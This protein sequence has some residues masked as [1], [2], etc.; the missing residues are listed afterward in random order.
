MIPDGGSLC[1]VCRSPTNDPRAEHRRVGGVGKYA[2]SPLAKAIG[3][4]PARINEIVRGRRGVTAAT[5]LRLAKYYG[6][7]ARSWMNLQTRYEL[8]QADSA[9]ARFLRAIRPFEGA[10][11]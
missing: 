9:E 4:T 1:G 7:D 10:V 5:A 11:Q 8:A 2:R 3:V 6:T